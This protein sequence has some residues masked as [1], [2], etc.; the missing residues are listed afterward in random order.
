MQMHMKDFEVTVKKRLEE[1]NFLTNLL[2]QVI[3]RQKQGKM[4][5]QDSFKL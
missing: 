5:S 3:F 1:A 2:A 4:V